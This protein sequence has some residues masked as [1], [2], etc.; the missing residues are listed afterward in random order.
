MSTS[1]TSIASS[2]V[3]SPYG[4]LLRD[5]DGPSLES[6][7]AE[8]GYQAGPD[9]ADL[10]VAVKSRLGDADRTFTGLASAVDRGDIT[11]IAAGIQEL[12]DS[13]R[14]Q[15]RAADDHRRLASD[16][17][18]G[19]RKLRRMYDHDHQQ[20]ERVPELTERVETSARYI[21]ELEST[22]R[23][24]NRNA[25]RLIAACHARAHA[26]VEPF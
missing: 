1:P 18:E 7:W 19:A 22:L 10:I 23:R 15:S 9:P 12:K 20:A 25:A 16:R 8:L 2:T 4:R 26:D 21:R 11:L 13:Q 17:L 6:A 24:V 5:L 14:I 3:D